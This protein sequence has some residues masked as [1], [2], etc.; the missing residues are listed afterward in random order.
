[1]QNDLNPY[2]P[3]ASQVLAQKAGFAF[4]PSFRRGGFYAFC[5]WAS[6][7]ALVSIHLL[8]GFFSKPE[9][10]L[11]TLIVLPT[12]L[13]VML[14]CDRGAEPL[15]SVIGFIAGLIGIPVAILVPALALVYA[16]GALFAQG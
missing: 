4:S 16:L 5:A 15:K 13:I 1:M 6:Y 11:D 12:A 8:L 3:P 10:N 9:E 2:A 14:C 7:A